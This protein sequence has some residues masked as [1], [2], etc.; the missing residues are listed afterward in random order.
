MCP[1]YYCDLHCRP[2]PSDPVK[3]VLQELLDSD[4]RNS[5]PFPQSLAALRSFMLYDLAYR[6]GARDEPCF[7]RQWLRVLIVGVGPHVQFEFLSLG[8]A[9][10]RW[11]SGTNA[12]AIY[13]LWMGK[14]E[15]GV[16][17]G[18]S[19]ASRVWHLPSHPDLEGCRT[20]R[21]AA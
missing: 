6:L 17:N 13:G 9:I 5:V 1:S 3:K 20:P 21:A 10:S 16:R 18:T 4:R 19:R 8:N 15:T 11:S 7:E 14:V 2:L 12:D